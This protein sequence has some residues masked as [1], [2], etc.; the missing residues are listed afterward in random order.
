MIRRVL[1]ERELAFVSR[2]KEDLDDAYQTARRDR[3]VSKEVLARLERMRLLAGMVDKALRAFLLTAK[4]D[5]G[6]ALTVLSGAADKRTSRV[7]P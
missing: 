4:L 1:T 2:T 7:G 6:S 5:V 3:S